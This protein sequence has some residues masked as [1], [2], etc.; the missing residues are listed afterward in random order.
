MGLGSG[1]GWWWLDLRVFFGVVEVGTWGDDHVDL[2]LADG[3]TA[4]PYLF[5]LCPMVATLNDDCYF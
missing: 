1:V 4:K 2:E 5:S 3:R